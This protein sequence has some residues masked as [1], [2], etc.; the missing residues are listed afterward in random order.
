MTNNIF[1][2]DNVLLLSLVLDC[3]RRDFIALIICIQTHHFL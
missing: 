3:R 2:I 1:L